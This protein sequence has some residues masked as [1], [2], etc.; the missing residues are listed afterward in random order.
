MAVVAVLLNN[1]LYVANVGTNRALLCKSTVDG[2]QVTQ[3]NMDH[4]TENEDELFRLS[5]LGAWRGWAKGP[6]GTGRPAPGL[7]LVPHFG[8]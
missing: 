4:T 7:P 2:L 3:L 6:L 5:Q 1:K 8:S